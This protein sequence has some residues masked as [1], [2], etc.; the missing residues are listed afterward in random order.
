MC[1]NARRADVRSAVS[2]LEVTILAHDTDFAKEVEA[3]LVSDFENSREASAAD[4]ANGSRL[5]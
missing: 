4:F 1:Y 3:M 2:F 5:F